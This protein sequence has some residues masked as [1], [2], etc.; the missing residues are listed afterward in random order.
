MNAGSVFRIPQP[1]IIHHSAFI[2][3][4]IVPRW[5]QS[6]C[7]GSWKL[8]AGSWKLEPKPPARKLEAASEVALKV[9]CTRS[10]RPV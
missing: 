4:Y 5:M 2:I 3:P 7:T 10:S 1:F 6:E 9:A 8:E